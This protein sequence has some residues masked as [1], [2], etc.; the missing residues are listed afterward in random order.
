MRRHNSSRDAF[1]RSVNLL[2]TSLRSRHR[3]DCSND[4]GGL[5]P[6]SPGS[7]R[8]SFPHALVA[9]PTYGATNAKRLRVVCSCARASTPRTGTPEWFIG[10]LQL[11]LDRYKDN[12]FLVEK[13]VFA[14]TN[15]IACR[16]DALQTAT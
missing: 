2:F 13:T 16:S 7:R 3:S 5:S 14:N 11:D 6:S 10:S 4:G 8:R 12:P 1:G 15:P 9:A